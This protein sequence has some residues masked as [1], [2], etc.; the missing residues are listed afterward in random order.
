MTDDEILE[1]KDIEFYAASVN[2]WCNTALEFDKSIFTLSAGGIGLLITLLTTV[3]VGSS[4]LLHLFIAA[5]SFFLISLCVVLTILLRNR[6]HIEQVIAGSLLKDPVLAVLDY[7]AKIAFGIGV[8]LTAWIGISAATTSYEKERDK[9]A[10][11]K[12][13]KISTNQIATESFNGLAAMQKSM[14]NLGSMRATASAQTSAPAPAPEPAPAP[15]PSTSTTPT[16][17]SR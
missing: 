13:Q 17:T 16:G 14:N 8:L 9:M 5:I 3:G 4:L 11:E 15:Q 2:A 1:Q 7:I 10:N 6:T 12:S